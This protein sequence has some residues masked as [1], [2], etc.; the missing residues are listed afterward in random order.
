MEAIKKAIKDAENDFKKAHTKNLQ[1]Y[2]K[3]YLAGM[4]RVLSIVT[5]EQD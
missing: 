4:R 5:K 2:F 1:L 3:G